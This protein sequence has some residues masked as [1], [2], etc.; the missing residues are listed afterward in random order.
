M[1]E[2]EIKTFPDKWKLRYIIA[3]RCALEGVWRKVPQV[4]SKW[5]QTV[6]QIH[7]KNQRVLIK[8]KK[9]VIIKHNVIAPFF[10]FSLLT[11]F[12]NN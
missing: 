4:E 12:K 11:D 3:K 2:G 9:S 7:M 1:N 5:H 6:F 8:V 10:F